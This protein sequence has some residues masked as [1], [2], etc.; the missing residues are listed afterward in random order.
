M[1]KGNISSSSMLIENVYGMRGRTRFL[2]SMFLQS[3]LK[4]IPVV[5][6]R[7]DVFD[8]KDEYLV[9]R[10]IMQEICKRRQESLAFSMGFG[11]ETTPQAEKGEL[12]A[13]RSTLRGGDADDFKDQSLDIRTPTH[14]P[15]PS[16]EVGFLDAS[17]AIGSFPPLPGVDDH[18]ISE[19]ARVY[20][21][22]QDYIKNNKPDLLDKL[23]LINVLI[24]SSYPIPQ[25]AEPLSA[26]DSQYYRHQLA[27][28][29]LAQYLEDCLY[30][31]IIVVDELQWVKKRDYDLTVALSKALKEASVKK[32]ALIMRSRPIHNNAYFI[33]DHL[34]TDRKKRYKELRTGLR[35][36]CLCPDLWTQEKIRQYIISKDPRKIMNN[37]KQKISDVDPLLIKFSQEKSG[38]RPG[39]I[40]LF[41]ES[42]GTEVY[43][44]LEIN[45][46]GIVCFIP[47]IQK[48]LESGEDVQFPVPQKVNSCTLKQIDVLDPAHEIVL[49]T[50]A[51]LCM[52]I[53][54]SCVKFDMTSLERSMPI[55]EYVSSINKAMADLEEMGFIEMLDD[56]TV[57]P[58]TDM[59]TIPPQTPPKPEIETAMGEVRRQEGFAGSGTIH[60]EWYL[61]TRISRKFIFAFGQLLWYESLEQQV[62]E[63]QLSINQCQKIERVNATQ[64]RLVV[65]DTSKIFTAEN[66][67]ESDKWLDFFQR[68]MA[69]RREDTD[70]ARRRR[71]NMSK[72]P[73]SR[74]R[75]ERRDR[76]QGI[77][78]S[79]AE[80]RT[81]ARSKRRIISENR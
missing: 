8:D 36:C 65:G 79:T 76:P 3:A 57:Y 38:G 77:R 61:L 58:P 40:H 34:G 24:G 12:C 47:E 55:V 37:A 4:E 48:R 30:C 64:I 9:W 21:T 72:L 69:G 81:Q 33:F 49:K 56:T 26:Q 14:N 43:D 68:E 10:N 11:G 23:N 15:R 22:F 73:R 54:E 32:L 18:E 53:D 78:N 51:A 41:V 13:F 31:L 46:R 66:A 70:G 71:C 35:E 52:G 50:A 45:K 1:K 5:W 59:S 25:G 29:F 63:G 20:D 17:L 80:N 2:E 75:R 7:G 27:F 74:R 16:T 42:L 28:A 67:A 60:T 39:F 6:C 19:F 44:V 62:P